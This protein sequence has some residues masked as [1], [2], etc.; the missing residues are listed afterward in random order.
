V[1]K[2]LNDGGYMEVVEDVINRKIVVIEV[3][4]AYELSC[5]CICDVTRILG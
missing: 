1:V 3:L 4:S 5:G 2:I